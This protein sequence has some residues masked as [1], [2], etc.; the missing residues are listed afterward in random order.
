MSYASFPIQSNFLTYTDTLET[1]DTLETDKIKE[2]H[3]HLIKMGVDLSSCKC[4]SCRDSI[5]VKNSKT[6][7]SRSSSR[8]YIIGAILFLIA[9]TVSIIMVLD[10]VACI[11][12]SSTCSSNNTSLISYISLSILFGYSSIFCFI[13]GFLLQKKNKS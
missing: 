5:G 12:D 8:L 6:V 4:E 7:N 3:S 1:A 11:N 9:M 2:Y 13:K 10:G